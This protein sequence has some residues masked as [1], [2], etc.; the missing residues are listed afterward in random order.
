[1][2]MWVVWSEIRE[3]GKY[4]EISMKGIYTTKEL[5]MEAVREGMRLNVNL[6]HSMGAIE[7]EIDKGTAE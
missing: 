4:M 1:M 5:A 7:L 3:P 6:H 2:K